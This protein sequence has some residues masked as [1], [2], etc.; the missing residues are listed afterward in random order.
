MVECRAMALFISKKFV[1]ENQI[2]THSLSCEILL[3]NIDRTKNHAGGITQSTR[4]RLK[5]G[6]ITIWQQFL[7]TELGPKDI[8]LGLPWLRSMNP[9]IDWAEGQMCMNSTGIEENSGKVELVAV[10]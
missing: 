7:V 6:K 4:L 9:K 3:Y 5:I 2:C 1:R 8:V 10:N